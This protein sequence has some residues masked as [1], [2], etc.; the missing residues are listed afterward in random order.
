[1]LRK[2]LLV[3][4]LAMM[5]FVTAGVAYAGWYFRDPIVNIAGTTVTIDIGKNLSTGG[6]AQQPD[7]VLVVVPKEVD[8][9]VVDSQGARVKIAHRGKV[10]EDAERIPFTVIVVSPKTV[11]GQRYQVD[12]IVSNGSQTWEAKGRSG[13]PIRVKGWVPGT[14]DHH[15]DRDHG[16][17]H[18]HGHDD[19]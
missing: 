11:E 3:G 19:D 8:A 1:M 12:V 4:F 2:K 17:G 5:L 16:H 15:G 7:R 10:K 9:R 18:G 6:A 14:G 13:K